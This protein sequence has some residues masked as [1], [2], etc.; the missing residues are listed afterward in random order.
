MLD[1]AR[2]RGDFPI[3][4]QQ[5]NG[6]RLVY[7][8]NAATT[9]K[10]RQVIEALVRYYETS[11]A[12]IHRGI[13]TLA[14]R[15]TE[16]Y[17]AARGSVARFIGAAGPQEVIFT[18]NATEAINLVA[19]AWGDAS[20]SEGDEI[21]LTVMEHHSNIVPWQL[22]AA[23][24]GARLRYAGI[25]PDGR[26]D[27]DGLRQ[28]I[29]PRTRLVAVTQM[30]NVL[31]TINPVGDIAEMAHAAG[32]LLL[33][34]GAQSV[35]HLPVDVR[36]LGADFL[37]FSAH[38]MLGPTGV[39]VLWAR[40]ELLAAMPPFLGGG[41]MIAVV[42]EETSTW[43]DLPHKFEAG[44]PN[45]ADVIAFGEAIAYLES[46]GM[47]NVRRHEEEL[48]ALALE[49]LGRVPGLQIFGPASAAERGGVVSFAMEAA[50]PHDVATIADGY[51]VAIRAGHHCA[52]L[53]MRALGVPATSRASF[54]IY[55]GEDDL[56]ALIEALEGVNRVFGEGRE[57]AAVR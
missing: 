40:E 16:Q 54:S 4:G 27:L 57:R 19:R 52:Q 14:N 2:I 43:A 55:N 5:V 17:E 11:N 18:R 45:I 10:P 47:A 29:G 21:V 39:G 6:R 49:R 46:I 33:V 15:A 38:K 42:R 50:H 37:A 44:T 53:L 1:I 32:A 3:L 26:L 7:L 36:G 12:N 41:D 48:T 34:D 13:H 24:K 9:Q 25:T 51:G 56:E 35:P 23:R 8:D 22:L 28:L 20:I 31:G 30:S